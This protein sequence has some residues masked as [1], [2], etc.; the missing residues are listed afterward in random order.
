VRQLVAMTP[1]MERQRTRSAPVSPLRVAMAM[2]MV[3]MVQLA[4]LV[5]PLA[6]GKVVLAIV[7]AGIVATA[8]AATETAT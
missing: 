2:V 3:M 6:W 8:M 5:I 1:S 4:L 7:R